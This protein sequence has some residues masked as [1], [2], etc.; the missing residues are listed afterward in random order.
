M[1][2]RCITDAEMRE[3]PSIMRARL[4]QALEEFDSTTAIFIGERLVAEFPNSDDVRLLLARALL[5]AGRAQ[6]ATGLLR[7]ATNIGE[8]SRF[9]LAHCLYL[10][11]TDL[12]LVDLIRYELSVSQVFATNVR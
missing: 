8:K 9:L 12:V 5:Q 6:Q 3:E 2:I 4:T 11:E 10:P 1:L 7:A